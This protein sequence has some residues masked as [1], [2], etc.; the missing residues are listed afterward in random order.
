MNN[1]KRIGFA[2]KWIDHEG[3]VDG[4]KPKDDAKQYNTRSTTVRWLNNQTREVAEQ[5][6]WDLMVHNIESSRK[7]VKRVGGLDEHLRMVR[8]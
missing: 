4:I 7:L 5:R 8:F 1:L 6:L 2:C 3:Q